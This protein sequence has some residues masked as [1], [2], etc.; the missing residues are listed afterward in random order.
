MIIQT[1]QQLIEER[2]RNTTPNY[3]GYLK[4]LWG[5]NSLLIIQREVNWTPAATEEPGWAALRKFNGMASLAFPTERLENFDLTE[6]IAELCEPIIADTLNPDAPVG[7]LGV[8]FQWDFS[9]QTD[10]LGEFNLTTL[11]SGL[12]RGTLYR[13]V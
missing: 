1:L 5:G 6:L 9:K 12:I 8:R 10:E 13:K 7:Q 3:L 2:I 11:L 4:N